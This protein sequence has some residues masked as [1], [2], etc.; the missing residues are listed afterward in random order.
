MVQ[1]LRSVRTDP[2]RSL[3]ELG[4]T[5]CALLAL[6][7]TPNALPSSPDRKAVVGDLYRTDTRRALRALGVT[8]CLALTSCEQI[9]NTGFDPEGATATSFSG[10]ESL[11]LTPDG[12]YV[13]SWNAPE[14]VKNL[15][16]V[17]YEVYLQKDLAPS[18]TTGTTTPASINAIP[19][20]AQTA[21]REISGTKLLDLP[22]EESPLTRGTLIASVTGSRVHTLDKPLERGFVYL[23]Q[24]RAVIPGGARDQNRRVLMYELGTT[25]MTFG[26]V[27]TLEMTPSGSLILNWES[28]SDL[29]GAALSTISY[30]VY[31][32]TSTQSPEAVLAGALV[33]GDPLALVAPSAERASGVSLTSTSSSLGQRAEFPEDKTPAKIGSPVASVTGQ[34]FHE[35]KDRL[36]SGRTYIFQVKARGPNGEGDKNNR[37]IVH[38]AGF[39]SLAPFV[40]IATLTSP[41]TGEVELTWDLPTDTTVVGFNIYEGT[42]FRT[43]VQ[44]VD[45][46]TQSLRIAGLTP[47][48]LA[49]YGVRAFDAMGNEDANTR[50]LTVTVADNTPP[51]FAGID[52]LVANSPATARTARVT[53]RAPV[54]ITKVKEF[55]IYTGTLEP[56]AIGHDLDCRAAANAITCADKIDWSTPALVVTTP[57]ALQANLENLHDE[58]PLFIAVRVVAKNNVEDP[59]TVVRRIT[60]PDAGAPV[61]AGVKTASIVDGSARLT[62]DLPRGRVETYRLRTTVGGVTT[63]ETFSAWSGSTPVLTYTSSRLNSSSTYVFQL[64]ALDGQ[65][66]LETNTITRSITTGDTDAPPAVQVITATSSSETSARVDFTPSTA[67]DLAGYQ[68]RSRRC[69]DAAPH[70]APV[71]GGTC[72]TFSSFSIVPASDISYSGTSPRVATISGLMPRTRYK[73]PLLPSTRLTTSRSTLVPPRA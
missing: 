14:N 59:N 26:G 66:N 61:F 6:G 64:N 50:T 7:A 21:G 48:R 71:T 29:N 39:G 57:S 67:T 47:G 56:G 23:F 9:A 58:K 10:V 63:T 51:T 41:D 35:L 12:K 27:S 45:Q 46:T 73:L 68:L 15:L 17:T 69:L 60:M 4:A 20:T 43:V 72:T 24:V 42:A 5:S 3:C 28:P 40:G 49:S 30:D 44:S 70:A 19:S 8:M 22:D 52:N 31:A 36:I 16:G 18:S 37:V 34:N 25:N 32:A 53:W 65:S 11:A 55:R 2:R 38:R 13:L 62:W 33:L 54:P 1:D